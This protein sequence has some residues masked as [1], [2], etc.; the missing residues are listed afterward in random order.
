[1]IESETVMFTNNWIIYDLER[2]MKLA[3][4]FWKPRAI[5]D[6]IFYKTLV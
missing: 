4:I 6:V 5:T 2:H 1:M 3:I